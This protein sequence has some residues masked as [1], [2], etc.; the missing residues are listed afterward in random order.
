MDFQEFM[1]GNALPVENRKVTVS[2]RFVKDGKAIP[3]EIRAITNDEDETLRK[4]FMRRVPAPG[5]AGKRGQYVQD[6]DGPGYMSALCAAC[7]VYPNLND[8][9]LQDSY[10][11]KDAEAL[12]RAMLT[13]G[14]LGDLAAEVQEHCGFDVSMADKVEEAKN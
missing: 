6:F 9:A 10:K 14:E 4:N 5:K 12:L 2:K 7:V 8:A 11:V 3:W 1:L 13:P